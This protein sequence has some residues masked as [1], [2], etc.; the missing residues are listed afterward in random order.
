MHGHV[1][2][3]TLN[4]DQKVLKQIRSKSCGSQHFPWGWITRVSEKVPQMQTGYKMECK[5]LF[6]NKW[7]GRESRPCSVPSSRRYPS[8]CHDQYHSCC[9]CRR[10]RHDNHQRLTSKW[11]VRLMPIMN[12]FLHLRKESNPYLLN[13]IS[14]GPS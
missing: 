8:C 10:R 11:Q 2:L 6:Y 5:E 7:Q 14:T 12:P 4:F 13:P 3:K 9:C 1:S